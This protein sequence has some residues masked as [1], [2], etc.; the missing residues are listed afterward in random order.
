M[1]LTQLLL[2]GP[3]VL[4]TL[5]GTKTQT[6]RLDGLKEINQYPDNFHRPSYFGGDYAW[7]LDDLSN[8]NHPKIITCPYGDVGNQLWVRETWRKDEFNGDILYKADEKVTYPVVKWKPSIHMP[9]AA[10]RA[11]LEITNIRLARLQDITEEDAKAEGVIFGK[12][13]WRDYQKEKGGVTQFVNSC[14]SARESFFTLWDS[15][16]GW[17]AASKNPWVWAI[18]YKLIKNE[19]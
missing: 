1:K 8:N 9:K 3:L 10:C 11:F 4:A 6:R 16:Y 7:G 5:N 19:A 13:Y 12:K 17:H 14:R 2:K 15:V 18:E